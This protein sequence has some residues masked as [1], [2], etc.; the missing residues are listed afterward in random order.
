MNGPKSVAAAIPALA[1]AWAGF[2]AFAQKLGQAASTDIAWWR[3]AS[4]LVLCLVLAV[5]AAFALRTR[6]R[7]AAPVFGPKDRRLL[8]VESLRLS[9]QVDVCLLECDGRRFLVSVSPQGAAILASD[10][11]APATPGQP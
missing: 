9:H 8:L 1:L 2:P 5:C 3:V 7:G 6:L 4:A 11:A 10:L